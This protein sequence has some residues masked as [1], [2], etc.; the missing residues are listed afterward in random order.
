MQM[1]PLGVK[2]CCLIGHMTTMGVASLCLSLPSGDHPEGIQKYLIPIYQVGN[3][4]LNHT[5][6]WSFSEQVVFEGG[7]CYQH[8]VLR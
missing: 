1:K 8:T 6:K 4:W 2:L 7:N 5:M 3:Q